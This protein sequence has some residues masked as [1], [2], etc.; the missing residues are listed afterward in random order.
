MDADPTPDDLLLMGRI[1]R[2]HGVRGE[3]KVTPDTDEP[4]R[5]E[6]VDRLFLGASPETARARAVEGIRFQFPKGRTVVLLSLDGVDDLDG[7]EA[8]RGQNLYAAP[9]DLPPLEDGEAYLHDLIGLV[10]YLVDENDEA[11]GDPI[12]TV[13]DIFDGAQLLFAIRRDGQPDVLVP[14]VEAIVADVDLE[15]RRLLIRPLDGLLD[16]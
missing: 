2:P 7:A 11:D 8:L 6:L 14:D 15:G 10:A 13:H 4:S 3:M 12:G 9:S 5:F 1:G 16:T